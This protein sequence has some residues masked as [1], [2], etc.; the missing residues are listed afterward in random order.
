MQDI[1]RPMYASL[2]SIVSL[3]NGS[4]NSFECHIGVW[5]GVGGLSPVWFASKKML[6]IYNIIL[7]CCMIIVKGGN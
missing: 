1:V 7:M 6:G 5:Q 3:S 2:K 4:S